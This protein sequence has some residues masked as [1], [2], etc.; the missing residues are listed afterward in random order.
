[1]TQKYQCKTVKSRIT[2]QFSTSCCSGHSD[3][4]R[5]FCKCKICWTILLLH[6]VK[7][8]AIWSLQYI[9]LLQYM[10]LKPQN[11]LYMS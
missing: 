2:S 4:A 9:K 7:N 10:T 6:V 5:F 11:S 8:W 3:W 1:M